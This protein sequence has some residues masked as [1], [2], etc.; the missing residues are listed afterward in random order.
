MNRPTTLVQYQGGGYDGCFWEWNFAYIDEDLKFHDLLSSGSGAIKSMEALE[1][2]VDRGPNIYYYDT[3]DKEKMLEFANEN[4]G[5]LVVAV[6]DLLYRDF[7]IEIQFTCAGCDTVCNVEPCTM[8]YHTGKT[9]SDLYC[10]ECHALATFCPIC[11]EYVSFDPTVL[12]DSED[13]NVC[14]PCGD[15]LNTVS[16]YFSQIEWEIQWRGGIQKDTKEDFLFVFSG[17]VYEGALILTLGE[18]EFALKEDTLYILTE[19]DYHLKV[20]NEFSEDL[21]DV[22]LCLFQ[23]PNY[24]PK[25][26]DFCGRL[27]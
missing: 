1:A 18:N 5:A 23:I 14:G 11:D 15:V 6:A 7:E 12:G 21:E 22:L 4:A 3:S 26:E 20:Y 19:S 13:L 25:E 10:D 8:V 2:Y 24:I 16:D 9:T 17:R 27:I